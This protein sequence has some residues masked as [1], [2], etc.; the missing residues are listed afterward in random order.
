MELIRD[1]ANVVGVGGGWEFYLSKNR[2]VVRGNN[3]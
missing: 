3:T 2:M 1:Y